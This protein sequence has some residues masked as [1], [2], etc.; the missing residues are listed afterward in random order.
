MNRDKLL[1]QKK[2]YHSREDVKIRRHIY[3]TS[4]ERRE[5]SKKYEATE[6]RKQYKKQLNSIRYICAICGK[7]SQLAKKKRHEKSLFHLK[8]LSK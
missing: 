2:D 7:E 4:N 3:D 8:H 5:A 6:E 1:K